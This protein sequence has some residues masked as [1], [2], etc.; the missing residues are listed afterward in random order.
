M[1]MK[2]KKLLMLLMTLASLAVTIGLWFAINKSEPEYTEVK[3]VVESSETVTHKVKNS[4][5]TSY[6]VKV[7]YNNKTYD[8]QNCHNLQRSTATAKSKR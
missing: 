8:L 6:A 5:V 2:T 7:R 4:K 3:A 1:K